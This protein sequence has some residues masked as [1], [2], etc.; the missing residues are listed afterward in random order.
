MI[1]GNSFCTFPGQ[2]HGMTSHQFPRG[3][4]TVELANVKYGTKAN[5]QYSGGQCSCTV[6]VGITESEGDKLSKM[7]ETKDRKRHVQ[8]GKMALTLLL[9]DKPQRRVTDAQLG[10]AWGRQRS[11]P[12]FVHLT[13]R[14][15][16]SAKEWRRLPASYCF[17]LPRQ[18]RQNNEEDRRARYNTGWGRQ[19]DKGLK[20]THTRAKPEAICKQSHG[21]RWGHTPSPNKQI[22]AVSTDNC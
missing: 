6:R 14:F 11:L 16:F 1:N 18:E 5:Y 3:H 9:C 19:G 15:D 10:P 22:H 21:Y 12:V 8:R 4:F 20:H 17:R 7:E 2:A 13:V